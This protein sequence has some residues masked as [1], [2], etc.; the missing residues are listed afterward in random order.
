[1]KFTI[2]PFLL[3][4]VCFNNSF[5]QATQMKFV[6]K[7]VL[8]GENSWDYL[9]AD[10]DAGKLYVSHG[11]SVDV[12]DSRSHQ[13][14]G[15]I[16]DIKGAHG[17]AIAGNI[18]FI[19]NGRSNMVTE[20]ETQNYNILKQVPTGENPDYILYDAF[21]ESVFVF[22]NGDSSCTVLSAVNGD[23]VQT[24]KLSGSPEAAVSDGK[25][26]IY[27]NLEDASSIVS[28]DAKSYTIK[29]TWPLSP[30]QEPTGLAID[31]ANNRLFSVCHNQMM[32]IL[33]AATGKIVS[34][35]EIGKRVDGVAFDP[36]RGVAVSSNGEGTMTVVKLVKGDEYKVLETVKTEVGARTITLDKKTHHFYLSTAKF[37]PTPEPT[38][39][40]PKPKRNIEPDSFMVLEYS[41]E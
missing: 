4:L 18:G 7:T 1:M 24:F 36:S 40:N 2:V 8:G 38:K 22:N 26:T 27:V 17:I 34:N 14:L 37:L 3:V 25:G 15:V 13:K 9:F 31:L 39:E 10:S 30:G 41:Y 28:F 21:S 11:T 32:V 16:K 35:V 20:F 19:T 33:D 5:G 6:K 12:L 29:S 23:I